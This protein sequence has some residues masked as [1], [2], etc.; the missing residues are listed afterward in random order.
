MQ[1]FLSFHSGKT[2]PL[3]INRTQDI[4]PP[5][6]TYSVIGRLH[7]DPLPQLPSVYDLPQSHKMFSNHAMLHCN[8]DSELLECDSGRYTK[9]CLFTY[10]CVFVQYVIL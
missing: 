7:N 8:S 9:A 6:H 2:S 10:V 4:S 1:K 3:Q 5:D